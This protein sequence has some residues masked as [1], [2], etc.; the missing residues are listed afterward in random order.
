MAVQ[1]GAF[2]L[3]ANS[4]CGVG[5]S[6]GV[7]GDKRCLE[8]VKGVTVCGKIVGRCV[9]ETGEVVAASRD[10]DGL[11]EVGKELANL[12]QVVVVQGA[13]NGW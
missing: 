1:T 5:G 11:V 6:G 2:S 10:V 7:I 13:N 8:M 3:Y 12:L 4:L 9:N